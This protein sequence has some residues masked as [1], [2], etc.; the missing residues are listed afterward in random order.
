MG[1]KIRISW[2]TVGITVLAELED[3]KNLELCNEFWSCLPF[4]VLQSHPV[5]S[6]AAIFAWVPLLSESKVGWKENIL[7][8]PVGRLRYLQ[9]AGNK[10][11]IQYGKGLE[12][13]RHPVLGQVIAEHTSFLPEIGKRVWD[14]LFWD[15]DPI[16][17]TVSRVDE[18]TTGAEPPTVGNDCRDNVVGKL[19]TKADSL[20][21]LEPEDIQKMRQGRI[22]GIGS[23]G[24]YFSSWDIANG[25]IRDY[26]VNTIPSILDLES[27]FSKEDLVE[28][29]RALDRPYS[30]F[31][32]AVGLRDLAETSCDVSRE[33]ALVSD[34]E[35]VIGIIKAYLMYGNRL[36]CWA[37]HYF[38]WHL[39]M[40]FNR[41]V[42]GADFPGRWRADGPDSTID[43]T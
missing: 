24:Q 21:L 17:V 22:Q 7:Q 28:L 26:F 12:D 25:M 4:S 37:H 20:R 23:F 3:D 5:V 29:F 31:F 15:K 10:L 38:P 27:R 36:Y 8:S 19:L 33:I 14:S 2:P 32:K 18:T 30:G 9:S 6:G 40:F 13:S 41:Q 35:S 34:K 11:S 42:D 16:F 39:G 1:R 43:R